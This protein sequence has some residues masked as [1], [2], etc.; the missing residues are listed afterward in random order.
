MQQRVVMVRRIGC[1]EKL[2]A[3]IVWLLLTTCFD[4]RGLK[5]EFRAA[6]TGT[7]RTLSLFKKLNPAE[8]PAVVR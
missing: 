2:P 5:L 6:A 4:A 7:E 1:S 3:S 8:N